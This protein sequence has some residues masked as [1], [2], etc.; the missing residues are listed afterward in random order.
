MRAMQV[1]AAAGLSQAGPLERAPSAANEVWFAGPYVVRISGTP[2]T[3]RLAYEARIAAALPP[4]ARYPAIV[5]HGSGESADWLILERVP[6][7]VLSRNWHAMEDDEREHAVHAV[8][9]ALRALHRTPVPSG[10]DVPFG[11]DTLECPHQ[12]PVART[13]Q[14]L[15]RARSLPHLD[16]AVLDDA[17]ELVGTL[18][19][20]LDPEPHPTL[21]H[22]DLHLENVLWDGK[23]VTALIDFE[24]SRG[25]PPDLDLD[26][27]LRFCADPALH[28]AED[29]EHLARR[30]DYRAVPRWLRAA[31][32]ALFG[33]PR[34]RERLLLYGLAYDIRHLLLQPPSVPVAQLPPL[35]AW[36]RIRKA[37]DGHTHLGWMEL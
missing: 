6:G 25:G 32:P 27:L 1:L 23:R 12:L 34:L 22:G 11:A 9:E 7:Q 3:H 31:H 26:V 13:M 28:V 37:V 10:L 20:A 30:D 19:D 15:A 5:D 35:H 2:G 16:E 8:G 29:Y 17:I 36:N 21:I 33:H 24:F 18:A 14:L 4:E